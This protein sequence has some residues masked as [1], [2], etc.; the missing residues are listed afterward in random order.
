MASPSRTRS[1]TK[2]PT[3]SEAKISLPSSPPV[4]ITCDCV[5]GVGLAHGR[6]LLGLAPG[7]PLDEAGEADAY[8]RPDRLG[9]VLADGGGPG[10]GGM[11]AGP[12]PDRDFRQEGG[13]VAE[14]LGSRADARSYGR[15][16]E[17]PRP[18][19]GRKG[20]GGVEIH[21][22][23]GSPGEVLGRHGGADEV[24]AHL[25]GDIGPYLDAR[26][27]AGPHGRAARPK[28]E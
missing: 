8:A 27:H 4:P 22:H 16:Q 6:E 10:T 3:P 11:I 18:P 12:F 14:G 19:E 24:G 28:A 9:G 21:Y 2:R 17:I 5:R 26:P 7:Y 23:A 25:R 20:D 15:A 1:G 13:R